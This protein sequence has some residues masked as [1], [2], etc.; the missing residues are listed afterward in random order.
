M[1]GLAGSLSLLTL[2]LFGACD[3]EAAAPPPP[4]KITH[5]AP[6]L[7]WAS[8]ERRTASPKTPADS[9]PA[10]LP[11]VK[12][13]VASARP[14]SGA[15]AVTRHALFKRLPKDALFVVDAPEVAAL[16]DAFMASQ[17]ARLFD[18]PSVESQLALGRAE[19]C[20]LLDQAKQEVPEL[21]PLLALIPT[22]KGRLALAISG[23]T[24]ETLAAPGADLPWIATFVYDPGADADRFAS[25]AAPLL[26][27]LAKRGKC[28]L[29]EKA[30]PAWGCEISSPKFTLDFERAGDVFELRVGGRAAMIREL[31]AA[32]KRVDATSFFSTRV[33][34]EASSVEAQ[35]ARPIVE[36]HLQ[37]TSLWD[38]LRQNGNRADNRVLA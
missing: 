15:S 20:R 24:A 13:G 37:L 22:L 32:K 17:L 7:D 4:V 21:A 14:E 29:V 28:T 18:Q 26:S 2:G 23:L 16:S 34:T 11:A 12:P 3:G 27:D 10:A 31:A 30:E 33:A 25:V 6:I 19:L 35:G 36:V 38:A 8:V 5:V 1:R 9:A